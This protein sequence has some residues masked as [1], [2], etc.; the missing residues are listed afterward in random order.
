MQLPL[1]S[2]PA[3]PSAPGR[4]LAMGVCIAKFSGNNYHYKTHRLK[5]ETEW[6]ECKGL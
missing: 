6:M 2:I 1:V 4:L 5:P 3:F